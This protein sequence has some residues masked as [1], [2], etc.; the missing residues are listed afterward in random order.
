M[1]AGGVGQP[2]DGVGFMLVGCLVWLPV[3]RRQPEEGGGALAAYGMMGIR[4][5][6]VRVVYGHLLLVPAR[7]GGERGGDVD[8]DEVAVLVV[9]V[10]VAA[11]EPRQ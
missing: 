7:G 11:A 9:V 4:D 10:F 2:H 6:V 8:D 1:A 5:L 3:G